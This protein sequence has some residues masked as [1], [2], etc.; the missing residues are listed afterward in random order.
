[1]LR[2]CDR[3]ERSVTRLNVNAQ[4]ANNPEMRVSAESDPALDTLAHQL[5]QMTQVSR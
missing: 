2:A 4:V 3:Y 5:E 1:M